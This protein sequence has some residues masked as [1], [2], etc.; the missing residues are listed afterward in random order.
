MKASDI[1]SQIPAG[2][3]AARPQT[4]STGRLAA[5]TP[6]PA[7][8]PAPPPAPQA[9]QQP[10]PAMPAQR[11]AARPEPRPAPQEQPP[12]ARPEPP[13]SAPTGPWGPQQQEAFEKIVRQAL[14]TLAPETVRR[15]TEEALTQA[16]GN[17]TPLGRHV[18]ETIE[19]AAREIIAPIAEKV[20]REVAWEVIPDLA[21]SLVRRR[22]R[23]LE[24]GASAGQ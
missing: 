11:A 18:H 19:R 17:A 20:A 2:A 22:I 12:A 3:P 5:L 21:E 1:F 6:P 10:R 4:T 16:P 7:Q 9:T 23:E 13:A 15:V 14:S 8:A 24:E